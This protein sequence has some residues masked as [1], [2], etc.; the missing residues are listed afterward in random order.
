MSEALINI[1]LDLCIKYIYHVIIFV[2]CIYFLFCCMNSNNKEYQ[3]V[4]QFTSTPSTEK[5][6]TEK[7]VNSRVNT[8][9]ELRDLVDLARGAKEKKEYSYIQ[10]YQTER[11][12]VIK[13]NRRLTRETK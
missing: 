11:A 4:K 5:T 2:G 1:D 7:K 3:T 9:E 6:S 10:D 13:F 12:M 8:E